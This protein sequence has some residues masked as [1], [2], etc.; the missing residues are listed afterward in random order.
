M[1]SDNTLFLIA[2][3]GLKRSATKGIL[4]SWMW[5]LDPAD[6]RMEYISFHMTKS[7][8]AKKGG[9]IIDY[10]E[11]TIEEYE[12]HQAKM[13]ELGEGQMN[14]REEREIILWRPIVKWNE[15]WPVEKR[16]NF[17]SYKAHGKVV[18][19]DAQ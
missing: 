14:S 6:K 13:L 15:L 4:E 18:I 10:R 8:R 1:N 3:F 17:M 9:K 7:D 19:E 11:P 5:I 12:L 16:A 2:R